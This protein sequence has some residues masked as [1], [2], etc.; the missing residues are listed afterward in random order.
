[1]PTGPNGEKRPA[2]IVGCAVTVARIATGEDEETGYKQP[3]KRTGGQAGGLARAKLLT[4]EERSKIA[5]LGAT[6]RWEKSKEQSETEI[7]A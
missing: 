5:K 3:Q 6:I 7:N 2:D 4:E 1:M